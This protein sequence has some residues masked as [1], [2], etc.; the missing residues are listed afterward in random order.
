MFV[1]HT[2]ACYDF[3][4]KHRIFLISLA[5][6]GLLFSS[7]S[8]SLPTGS[9][10]RADDPVEIVDNT[11]THE[12]SEDWSY[13]NYN[14]WHEATDGS[15]SISDKEGHKYPKDWV[16]DFDSTDSTLGKKHLTC[17][18][19][20]YTTYETI[21]LKPH[22]HTY[23]DEYVADAEYHWHMP[24]CGHQDSVNKVR[25]NFIP[26][27]VDEA[28]FEHGG[29]VKEVCDVC[30]YAVYHLTALNLHNYSEAW[31]KDGH[32]HYHQCLD[33]GYESLKI[34]YTAHDYSEPEII[35]PATDSE[36]GLQE[37][38]C[39]I[40]GYAKQDSIPATEHLHT[41]SD[42]YSHNENYHWR[43]ATCEHNLK[44]DYWHHR[45]GEEEV[46]YS[47][48]YE[49]IGLARKTC[50]ECGYVK[51]IEL[52]KL[53]Y[54]FSD[55]W[56]KNETHHFHRCINEGH[57]DTIIDEELH[58]FTEWTINK[59]ASCSYEGH[60]YRFCKV[61]H[62]YEEQNLPL[63]DHIYD[64]SSWKYDKNY[65]WH[66]TKC[67]HDVVI[68]KEE[69]EL[70]SEVTL[71]PTFERNGKRHYQCETCDYNYDE[72]IPKLE[73]H[74]SD[75]WSYIDQS[76]H[77]H[78]CTDPG[79]ETYHDA[80]KPHNYDEFTIV[81]KTQYE[82]GYKYA[83]CTVCGYYYEEV[84]EESDATKSLKYLTFTI[85]EDSEG[86]TV[87]VNGCNIS[88]MKT[89]NVHS[90]TIPKIYNGYPVTKI[91]S[92]A[93]FN[94]NILLDIVIPD[95]IINIGSRAFSGCSGLNNVV[96]PD[97]VTY[98]G[99]AAFENCTSLTSLTVPF[100]GV[101]E[102]NHNY[103]R[104]IF[105]TPSTANS[106]LYVENLRELTVTKQTTVPKYGLAYITNLE[107]VTFTKGL[108][109]IGEYGF[110]S[111]TSLEDI[112]F[113]KD[114]TYIGDYA[115]YK[116][117][118]IKSLNLESSNFSIG[119][120]AF[121]LCEGLNE[122]KWPNCT[123]GQIG[124]NAFRSC[125]GLKAISISSG[126]NSIGKQ[127]FA[128][129]SNI[130]SIVF[131]GD[132][133]ALG[134][135]VFSSCNGLSSITFLGKIDT[136]TFIDTGINVF[137]ASSTSIKTISLVSTGSSPSIFTLFRT[138]TSETGHFPS[139][140]EKVIYLNSDPNIPAGEFMGFTVPVEF[141]QELGSIGDFAFANSTI[142]STYNASGSS[143]DIGAYAFYN[144][145]NLT[146]ANLNVHTVGEYA[147]CR[148]G[149]KT[150]SINC[151]EIKAYTFA[152]C[153]DLTTVVID[154]NVKNIDAD[155]FVGCTKLTN[156]IL[157]SSYLSLN[158]GVVY[159]N[160]RTEL[161][162][163]LPTCKSS[164]YIDPRVE[165]IR[166]GFIKQKDSVTAY[167]VDTGCNNFKSVNG[168]ILSK[169]GS[170]LI[171]SP[172]GASAT[173]LS[174]SGVTEIGEY[175]LYKSNY[176][177]FAI[178]D[179][180][181][182]EV[183]AYAFYESSALTSI[184]FTSAITVIN[185]YTFC[186]CTALLTVPD[187]NDVEEVK[188]AGFRSCSKIATI[189]IDNLKVA[190]DYSFHMTKADPNTIISHI[191]TIGY[192]AFYSIYYT[193]ITTITIPASVT[194][195]GYAIFYFN[196]TS[197]TYRYAGTTNKLLSIE[198]IA[199]PSNHK[200]IQV[201]IRNYLGYEVSIDM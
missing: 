157:N 126:I 106:P 130:L 134:D 88:L 66:G 52:P 78:Y 23:S 6:F 161:V 164:A 92:S 42:E 55:I 39:K 163:I 45:F 127:A 103:L 43:Q 97:S 139:S 144:C 167:Q 34:N 89:D 141:S 16:I 22:V 38:I 159:N 58:D 122:I 40:C 61:C 46:L 24:T 60:Q 182:N 99:E 199:P 83:A 132:L 173:S 190:G 110:Y 96:V 147:F 109:S 194:L 12:Y 180:T 146:E 51:N 121:N 111:C 154:A 15:H 131:E 184:S 4:M 72:S 174:L 74:Y 201:T 172:G 112:S 2:C 31:S 137:S 101:S 36:D 87:S 25:H 169:D 54:H 158:G 35:K 119:E 11:V 41:Y 135:N 104:A 75:E 179:S 108:T 68:D 30:G 162:T 100:I 102:I 77:F 64:L 178:T 156:I 20:G 176:T 62:Y 70:T 155:A 73:H 123:S 33:E 26:T 93:F 105:Y 188:E 5:T 200:I 136:A 9:S 13:D 19:C 152:Y 120:N 116:C 10:T 181:V 49:S 145:T 21:D 168:C 85:Y 128:L 44:V 113:A 50:T 151:E 183:G 125:E 170:K 171:K 65:H 166:D 71:E 149:L 153:T 86:K 53:S 32:G 48:T 59:V 177:S 117:S 8:N 124:A 76:G 138:S 196:N 63:T 57:E 37:M 107:S 148:S 165:S 28:N 142:F 79:Y 192:S 114:V 187:F 185:E 69:H 29:Q 94:V 95:T 1:L 90:I 189:V 98:I 143:I 84:T 191:K 186:D 198:R 140:L 133:G 7:C 129:C 193:N 3:S 160:N 197:I 115:F 56:S 67:G 91:E 195:L 47:P 150:V 18:V 118:S 82:D 175:A 27:I 80:T 14:H 17:E 81:P